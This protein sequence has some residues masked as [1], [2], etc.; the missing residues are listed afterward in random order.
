LQVQL[1]ALDGKETIALVFVY[2][3]A[4]RKI[5][6]FWS[7]VFAEVVNSLLFAASQRNFL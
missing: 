4:S 7:L 5:A 1:A 3:E 2:L 6:T